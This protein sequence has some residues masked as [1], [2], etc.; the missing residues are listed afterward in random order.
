MM[1]VEPHFSSFNNSTSVA[2][3]SDSNAA[4]S[5]FAGFEFEM[6]KKVKQRPGRD[7]RSVVVFS[8]SSSS[9]SRI[10]NPGR[11][12]DSPPY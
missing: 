8:Y 11:R 12:S 1:V 7:V 3:S 4:T 6:L 10:S 5:T 9:P 2:A